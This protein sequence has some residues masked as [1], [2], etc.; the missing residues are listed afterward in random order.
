MTV[1]EYIAFQFNYTNEE[2]FFSIIC[3]PVHD[4]SLIVKGN[5]AAAAS[6]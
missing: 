6:S 2:D 4:A 5:E 3:W 1:A